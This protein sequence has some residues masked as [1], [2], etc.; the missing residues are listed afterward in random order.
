MVDTF[1]SVSLVKAMAP[2]N[3]VLESF[4]NEGGKVSSDADWLAEQARF[5]SLVQSQ[6]LDEGP[7]KRY[8]RNL[9][10]AFVG[11]MES[12]SK[13]DLE[14]DDLMELVLWCALH[15]DTIPN[16][17]E[18]SYQSF[19]VPS[20]DVTS[21]HPQEVRVRV[22]PMNNDVALKLWGAAACLAEY[23]VHHRD[24]WQGKVFF[25]TGAG[26]GFTSFVLAACSH[27]KRVHMTDYS[28]A[29][30]QNMKHNVDINGRWLSKLETEI[31]VVSGGSVLMK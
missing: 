27:A 8:L 20:S 25:E 16:A 13:V 23:L 10:R 7:S 21:S 15:N 5:A 29:S 11:R 19:L 26:T 12:K 1:S 28:E 18:S 17:D 31:S 2:L 30:L 22:F 14:D 3:T 6:R 9:V 4:A 24:C